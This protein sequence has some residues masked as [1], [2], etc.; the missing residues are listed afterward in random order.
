MSLET[1]APKKKLPIVKL[2]IVAVVLA[3]LGLLALR[4]IGWTQIK[5]WIDAGMDLIRRAGPGW[6]F[7]AMMILPAFGVPMFAFTV[8]A[9]EAFGAQLGLPLV[10]VIS[11]ASIAVNLAFGYWIAR[12]AL[13]PF[14]LGLLQRYGY[15]I[16]TVT[17]ENALMVTLLV[18]LTPGPPYALQAWILGCAEVPF[19]MYMIVAWLSVVPYAL[20]GIILG[21]G[22]FEGNVKAVI[23]GA[24]LLVVAAVGVHWARAKFFKRES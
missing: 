4:F 5:E 10:I 7:A 15:T 19:K 21:K 11:L 16:P 23:A 2:A 22:L 8:P 1:A 6:F 13:R 14:L 17:K 3:G 12:Y 9:G 20:A 18:R 24:G